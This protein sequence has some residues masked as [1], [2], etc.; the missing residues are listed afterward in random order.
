MEEN[1]NNHEEDFD[2]TF[3]NDDFPMEES[4]ECWDN[5]S[6]DFIIS[7]QLFPEYG[8][9]VEGREKG[10]NGLGYVFSTHHPT[11]PYMALGELRKKISIGLSKRFI[12][13][14]GIGRATNTY[15]PLHDTIEGRIAFSDWGMTL[16]IDGI[17]LSY[18]DLLQM[19]ELHEGWQFKLKF[20]E[21]SDDF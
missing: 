6:R 7:C 8:Y 14:K 17:T 16:V 15:F 20:A 18:G 21:L 1:Q 3:T 13:N 2:S 9:Q 19:F 4:F 11:S 5:K 12:S 10:K